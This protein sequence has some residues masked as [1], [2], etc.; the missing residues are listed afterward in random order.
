MIPVKTESKIKAIYYNYVNG[1][2]KD[3]AKLVNKLSKLELVL[4]SNTGLVTV[5]TEL[6]GKTE[7]RLRFE[8]FI[9]NSLEGRYK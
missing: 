7:K 8:D 5:V 1:N 9:V 6:I 3:G 4:I 2:K